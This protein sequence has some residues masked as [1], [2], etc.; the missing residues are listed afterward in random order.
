M[1]WTAK[2]T[3]HFTQNDSKNS[4][5]FSC[6]SVTLSLIFHPQL[7]SGNQCSHGL[8]L[9]PLCT[10]CIHC[11]YLCVS[12]LFDPYKCPC[13]LL[14]ISLIPGSRLCMSWVLNK[15]SIREDKNALLCLREVNRR[16][17]LGKPCSQNAGLPS[18]W[19]QAKVAL[20]ASVS[21]PG[22]GAHLSLPCDGFPMPP[23]T[24]L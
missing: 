18:A 9:G 21:F 11:R 7:K 16:E 6:P 15:H 4:D 12:H 3:R 5:S 20:Q 17:H 2:G 10:L 1:F 14:S 13:C 24:I 8:E 23:G 22:A 19:N